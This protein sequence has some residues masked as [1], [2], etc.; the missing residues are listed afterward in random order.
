M[1]AAELAAEMAVA[2]APAAGA[3]ERDRTPP[4]A[5][6][7]RGSPGNRGRGRGRGPRRL[8]AGREDLGWEPFCSESQQVAVKR[9]SVSSLKGSESWVC[10]KENRKAQR[11]GRG[12]GMDSEAM[13]GWKVGGEAPESLEGPLQWTRSCHSRPL[14]AESV[15]P[16]RDRPDLIIAGAA[17]PPTFPK[18]LS[19]SPARTALARHGRTQS[20]SVGPDLVPPRPAVGPL[21]LVLNRRLLA[22][23]C[24]ARCSEGL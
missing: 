2:E 8:G 4:A 21:S 14:G 11:W 3:A 13:L 17:L 5:A 19:L 16:Q 22:R 20:T 9:S 7:A 24:G 12:P 18:H 15:R 10:P 6:G 23:L 1:A